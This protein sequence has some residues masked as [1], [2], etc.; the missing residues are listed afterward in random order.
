MYARKVGHVFDK[1]K[2][3]RYKGCVCVKGKR[4]PFY[5]KVRIWLF[6]IEK[7]VK[8]KTN[9]NVYKSC[10]RFVEN[11]FHVWSSW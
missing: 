9:L 11:E 8:Y 7:E 1:E 5:P 3:T 2:Y 10:R 6:Q 4:K